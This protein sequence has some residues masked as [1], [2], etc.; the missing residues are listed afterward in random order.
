MDQKII[1]IEEHTKNMRVVVFSGF[2]ELDYADKTA[3]H[4]KIEEILKKEAQTAGGFDRIV[5]VAGATDPGIGYVYEIAARS[6]IKTLG[7]VSEEAR[8][9]KSAPGCNSVIYIPDPEST[10]QVIDSSGN[11]YMALVARNNGVFYAFGGGRVTFSELEQARQLGI[12]THAYE[13]E[14]DPQKL[15]ER[16][17]KDLAK[18]IEVKSYTPVNDWIRETTALQAAIASSTL[19]QHL[20]AAYTVQVPGLTADASNSQPVLHNDRHYIRIDSNDYPVRFDNASATWRIYAEDNPAKPSLPVRYHNGQWQ[21]H[22]DVGIGGGAPA[23]LSGSL[24]TLYKA[25]LLPT[26]SEEIKKAPG[27]RYSDR[28]YIRIGEDHYEVRRTPEEWRWAIYSQT[29]GTARP[30]PVIFKNNQWHLA[31]VTND[32]DAAFNNFSEDA[33]FR[34]WFHTTIN[35][36]SLL[37]ARYPHDT[38]K[39]AITASRQQSL[40][41]FILKQF[42]MQATYSLDDTGTAISHASSPLVTEAEYS[43]SPTV[44]FEL[45][46]HI[47]TT[48]LKSRFIALQQANKVT[49]H[50]PGWSP[51]QEFHIFPVSAPFAVLNA[52]IPRISDDIPGDL[53]HESAVYIRSSG[54]MLFKIS[55][56]PSESTIDG[57]LTQRGLRMSQN[58]AAEVLSQEIMQR[59]EVGR[60]DEVR[61]L[62]AD[63]FS[64]KEYHSVADSFRTVELSPNGLLTPVSTDP[65]TQTGRQ[66]LMAMDAIYRQCRDFDKSQLPFYVR[67]NIEV[68]QNLVGSDPAAFFT[69]QTPA[70]ITAE[71]TGMLQTTLDLM[72]K[73]SNERGTTDHARNAADMEKFYNTVQNM[74]HLIRFQMSWNGV[75]T[76]LEETIKQLL[77]ADMRHSAYVMSGPHGLSV[78]NQVSNALPREFHQQ[79]AYVKRI[80]FETP[81]LF[82][83]AQRIESIFD[84]AL[85]TQKLIVMEPHPNNVSLSHIAWQDPV[86]L[87]RNIL[88][89][90]VVTQRTIVL[91]VTASHLNE[92]EITSLLAE[93]KPHIDNG[94]LN[95]VLVQS[96]TK[97]FQNGMDIASMGTAIVLNN[98]AGPWFQFNKVMYST[99]QYVPAEDKTYIAK[100]LSAQNMPQLQEYVDKIRSNTRLL[101]ALLEPV[102][103]FGHNNDNVFQLT[104]NTDDNT[105]YITLRPTDEFIALQTQEKDIGSINELDRKSVNVALKFY[106]L[107]A[108]K[109]LPVTERPSFGFNISNIALSYDSIRL[110]VGIEDEALIREYAHRIV[111]MGKTLYDQGVIQDYL[112]TAQGNLGEIVD[113]S[114]GWIWNSSDVQRVERKIKEKLR[115][116]NPAG[117]TGES[118]WIIPL[119]GDETTSEATRALLSGYASENTEVIHLQHNQPDISHSLKWN[120]QSQSLV[121]GVIL[122][123]QK[124]L[125]LLVIGHGVDDNGQQTFG[126]RTIDQLQ[127]DFRKILR[128]IPQGSVEQ[129][130]VELVGSRLTDINAMENSLPAV[131]ARV[132]LEEGQILGIHPDKLTL[133]ASQYDVRVMPDGTKKMYI[134]G[135]GWVSEQAI[136]AD[137]NPRSVW[138]YSSSTQEMMPSFKPPGSLGGVVSAVVP[139]GWSES[140]L[141]EFEKDIQDK[142]RTQDSGQDADGTRWIVQLQGDDTTT[143]AARDLF[144]KHPAN[145]ALIP[146][147]ANE[148]DAA[149]SGWAWNGQ[150]QKLVRG[151]LLPPSGRLKLLLVGHGTDSREEGTVVFGDRSVEELKSHFRKLLANIPAGG[152]SHIDVTL[153]GCLLVDVTARERGLPRLLADILLA[154]AVELGVN[155]ENLKL[156]ASQLYVKVLPGGRKAWWL[157]Y[158]GKWVSKEQ[159]IKDGVSY[160]SVWR[161]DGTQ[162]VSEVQQDRFRLLV[163]KLWNGI[164][165]HEF[166]PGEQEL[167]LRVL[168]REDIDALSSRSRNG[169]FLLEASS[170]I[171]DGVIDGHT[172]LD[173]LIDTDREYL[174][175]LARD[176]GINP[177]DGTANRMAGEEV[178]RHALQQGT[179]L[180]ASSHTRDG[181]GLRAR[182]L[183]AMQIASNGVLSLGAAAA[184]CRITVIN[185]RL[186]S[187]KLSDTEAS[188]LRTE[189]ALALAELGVDWSQELGEFLNRKFGIQLARPPAGAVTPPSS[190]PGPG[191]RMMYSLRACGPG[192]A[193]T[194][195]SALGTALAWYGV[196]MAAKELR[197]L[198]SGTGTADSTELQS[199][200]SQ[201]RVNLNVNIATAIISSGLTAGNAVAIISGMVA[202]L[203]SGSAT[204]VAVAKTASAIMSVASPVMGALLV[205]A[206]VGLWVYNGIKTVEEFSRHM[207]VDGWSRFELGFGSIFGHV[208]PS[209]QIKYDAEKLSKVVEKAALLEKS[210]L[211]DRLPEVKALYQFRSEIVPGR[212]IEH[213]RET[214]GWFDGQEYATTEVTG[215]E[216]IP[217][218]THHGVIDINPD[219][220][221]YL[222]VK[223]DGSSRQLRPDEFIDMRQ[224]RERAIKAYPYGAFLTLQGRRVELHNSAWGPNNQNQDSSAV[225]GKLTGALPEGLKSLLDTEPEARLFAADEAHHLTLLC[226]HG[227]DTKIS[228]FKYRGTLDGY[229]LEFSHTQDL[230]AGLNLKNAAAVLFHDLDGNGLADLVVVSPEGS[231]QVACQ[232]RNGDF[233]LTQGYS[234]WRATDGENLSFPWYDT[235]QGFGGTARTLYSYSSGG[236]QYS[237]VIVSAGENRTMVSLVNLNRGTGAPDGKFDNFIT[238]SKPDAGDFIFHLGGGREKRVRGGVSDDSFFLLDDRTFCKLKGHGGTD[239]LSFSQLSEQLVQGVKVDA[240][241]RAGDEWEGQAS[242]KLKNGATE[243]RVFFSGMEN[244]T[245]TRGNDELTGNDGDNVIDGVEGEDII[246]G[247]AG[248]DMLGGIRGKFIGGAGT[249]RYRLRRMAPGN[250]A[251]V[252]LI[253]DYTRGEDSHVSLAYRI[254]EITDIAPEEGKHLLITLS[255][256]GKYRLRDFYASAPA[257]AD[258]KMSCW[259]FSTRDGFSFRL[260]TQAQPPDSSV[261]AI[262]GIP[263]SFQGAP[264]EGQAQATINLYAG[265]GSSGARV[266]IIETVAG[267]KD[268]R[269]EIRLPAI[270]ELALYAPGS[271]GTVTGS[272]MPE[273]LTGRAGM[274]M[275]GG[276][277][278]DTYVIEDAAGGIVDID[279]QDSTARPERDTLIVPWA[280]SETVLSVDGSHVLLSHATHPDGHVRMRLTD[281]MSHGTSHHPVVRDAYGETCRLYVTDSTVFLASGPVILEKDRLEVFS[282]SRGGITLDG[283]S[284]DL[285][286]ENI[287]STVIVDHSG[288]GNSLAGTENVHNYLRVSGGNNSLYGNS[289]SDELH[290]GKDWDYLSGQGG[291]DV[292]YVQG[293]ATIDDTG[294]HADTLELLAVRG[295]AQEELWLKKTTDGSLHIGFKDSTRQ[296]MV[297]DHFNAD[298]PDKKIEHIV[299]NGVRLSHGDIDNLVS[300]MSALPAFADSQAVQNNPLLTAALGRWSPLSTS[301]VIY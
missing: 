96:G 172:A 42:Q 276:A 161:Y 7:I 247:G 289:L 149:Q 67:Q 4:T 19:P 31:L 218:S 84:A 23:N 20:Q 215:R 194:L 226:I 240:H 283:R 272:S 30:L 71:F 196:V 90:P 112:P 102:L 212:E 2:S 287:K 189:K 257:G 177:D 211:L 275:K 147:G 132:L 26:L 242:L 246:D 159:A 251:T 167:L 191:A 224:G 183:Y 78:I 179:E 260:K 234:L 5:V 109:G 88:S 221:W 56:Y 108:L 266:E 163:S 63:F 116:H 193:V 298:S 187:E 118:R 111:K 65:L 199:R 184:V 105:V 76:S 181:L 182:L 77:P 271:Q 119:Q 208:P 158:E 150:S 24:R 219:D 256:G 148:T 252:E 110:A 225:S 45:L 293:S 265:E 142:L 64:Y 198:S 168:K 140:G 299:M 127:H 6:G 292:Y 129:I 114:D 273:R 291:N 52:K 239:T 39:P 139:R 133:S 223:A 25:L 143:A 3:L 35:T 294:G 58:E 175:S 180:S 205:T 296:V 46:R 57:F 126:G 285:S 43:R 280:L 123:P 185:K 195:L 97:L 171:P 238:S 267:K 222:E 48:E 249:D 106:L 8:G 206:F 91:D 83:W 203:G 62:M 295:R 47:K 290:G 10:W 134:R 237:H 281:L 55:Q 53:R 60:I 61:Q 75:N 104:I 122:P 103:A 138:R 233:V 228:F 259:E 286:G 146:Y 174:K 117:D 101:R 27:F 165:F 17:Q 38:T 254:D 282:I 66:E 231:L 85:R 98:N 263:V 79:S 235:I 207:T 176:A 269:R 68:L 44:L 115:N 156:T 217:A 157:P 297:R 202:S 230:P 232:R 135:Q 186:A 268:V 197:E 70:M 100:M 250:T 136:P 51:E 160:K 264:E 220:N 270:F 99:Q 169:R 141:P 243:V 192:A 274:T 261:T 16:K 137:K 37:G 40:I 236:M 201:L 73:I 262:R 28:N 130:D 80:Y 49:Y 59:I 144:L 204:A 11:S 92:E 164:P 121:P 241:N 94:D 50:P 74:H 12:E 170:D 69:R 253:E 166:P 227:G 154:R 1:E 288:R 173:K 15:A 214:T 54:V 34:R 41:K 229:V 178:L 188:K 153:V 131:L 284:R 9:M 93:A 244:F 155:P 29:D 87:L 210:G 81:Q 33:H 22:N 21:L 86:A 18:G 200:I 82:P 162:M 190:G 128:K 245:G 89:G 151:P 120:N 301:P 255:D 72:V 124:T 278:A 113:P 152:V 216:S 209:L 213:R 14:P 277:G 279:L 125:K 107:D 300:A 248:N 36:L 13:Y 145:S 95:L 32:I 258:G